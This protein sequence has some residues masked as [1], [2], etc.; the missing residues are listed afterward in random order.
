MVYGVKDS[1]DSTFPPEAE[2]DS[3]EK[4]MHS[5]AIPKAQHLHEYNHLVS[6]VLMPHPDSQ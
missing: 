2:K 4:S 5:I 1:D 3:L 6:E